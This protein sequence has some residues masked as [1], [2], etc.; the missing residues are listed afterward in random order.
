MVK[1]RVSYISRGATVAWGPTNETAGLVAAG[2]VAGA[3]SDSFDASSTLEIFSL[4][5]GSQSGEMP[6]LGSVQLPERFHG[7]AWGA[8][9]A[10]A[11][12][13]YGMLAGGMVDGTVKVFNPKAMTD[14]SGEVQIASLERHTGGVRALE[15]NPGMPN[16]LATGAGDSEVLITDLNKPTSPNF[17]SPG[18]KLGGPPA[19]ISCVAWNRKVPHIMASTSHGGQSVVWDLKLKR[20]VINFTDPNNRAQRN[21]VVAWS[22]DVATR[23]IVASEDDR[24]PVLQMWDLRNATAPLIECRGHHKGILSASWCP[25]DSNL[26]IS[27]GKD[28]RTILWDPETAEMLGELPPAANWTFHVAWSPKMVGLVST[29]SFDGEASVYSLQDAGGTPGQATAE[30]FGPSERAMR[31]PKWLRRPCGVSFGFGGTIAFFNEK[32]ASLARVV[33][34]QTVVERSRELQQALESRELSAYCAAKAQAAVSERDAAEWSLMQV[35]CSHEQRLLLLQYLGLAEEPAVTPPEAAAPVDV[36]QPPASPAAGMNGGGEDDDPAA[37]F[38]QLAVAQDE[39]DAAD[40]AQAAEAAAKAA[41]KAEADA[42]A[43]AEADARA[44]ASGFAA[45]PPHMPAVTTSPELEQRL[46][47]AML[48]GNFDAAVACC[49]EAGRVA[50]ALV[51]AASGGPELWTHTRDTYLASAATPFMSTL[52]AVVHQDFASYVAE[53][54]LAC[55]KETLALLNTYAAPEELSNLCNQL[56]DR[57][58]GL[59]GESSAFQSAATLCYMCAANLH[60]TTALWEAYHVPSADGVTSETAALLDLMEKLAIFQEAAQTKEGFALVA[61]KVT[62][63]AEILS[64]QGCLPAAMQYLLSLP[65]GQA[66]TLEAA[67]LTERIYG[68]DSSLLTGPPPP[69]FAVQHIEVSPDVYVERGAVQAQ[70]QPPP[71]PHGGYTHDVFGQ[72]PAAPA[73]PPAYAQAPTAQPPQQPYQPQPPQQPYTQQPAPAPAPAPAFTYA[74][75]PAPAPAYAPT[76]PYAAAPEYAPAPAPPAYSSYAAQPA[77][78][79]AP[80]PAYAYQP[81]A[82]PYQPQPPSGMPPGAPAEPVAPP[83]AAPPPPPTPAY[84]PEPLIGTLSQLSAKCGAFNLPPLEARKLEDVNKRLVILYDKLRA[85]GVSTGVFE[86]MVQLG[87]GTRAPD[88]HV[89]P[90][91]TCPP[92][93]KHLCCVCMHAEATRARA[94]TRANALA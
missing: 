69:P 66:A 42:A 35:L 2:T 62:Q 24:N 46:S 4:D 32:S 19:D 94:H 59:M 34:D 27:S 65:A 11:S 85:G 18:A 17:Y 41:A 23:V 89:A 20:S 29:A 3:I 67:T 71:S 86:R 6:T 88:C 57:L 70:N 90:T 80:A 30:G 68:H 21:S 61:H 84:D 81:P 63:F 53:S 5:L 78:A 36:S 51:L 93:A 25:F 9:S 52:S 47:R 15:F 91:A 13:P 39:R 43:Q 16:L 73:M 44:A 14:G 7:L 60:K 48:N 77:P 92:T 87:Q 31:P 82:Q 37:I 79:P 49:L 74:A 40:A 72:Q 1:Q 8:G 22:P 83:P 33:T 54:D 45:A 75:P 38:S 10:E 56:G 55:W 26:L 12:M 28:N 64:S 76:A 58:E 50:D